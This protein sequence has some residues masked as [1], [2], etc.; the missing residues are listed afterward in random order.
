MYMV[1][2]MPHQSLRLLYIVYGVG[3]RVEIV[4][5]YDDWKSCRINTKNM[6]EHLGCHGFN[7]R[8]VSWRSEIYSGTVEVVARVESNDYDAVVRALET[9]RL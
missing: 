3:N 2:G 5:R 8:K 1:V 6:I 9:P 7:T 4:S